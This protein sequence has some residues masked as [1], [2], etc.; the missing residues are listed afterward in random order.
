M[1]KPLF[2]FLIVLGLVP[3]L[4]AQV[5]V[6]TTNPTSEL[7][8]QT[9]NTGVPALELNPQTAPVGSADGQLSV[10]GDKLYMYDETRSKWLSI[11]SN[12]LQ[13]GYALSADNQVLWFGGDIESSTNGA[14][15]PFDGTIIH[16]TVSSSGGNAS[17][18]MDLQ[19]NGSNVGNNLD[20]TLDGRFNLS[21]GSFTYTDFNIDFS[22]GDF[23]SI[24]A[25]N[26]GAAVEDPAAIIWV[27]WRQ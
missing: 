14:I 6:G 11:E 8:I 5:G 27:K 12:P 18:R 4:V 13:Y 1:R 25:A 17:K 20:P 19:I 16:V 7:E 2:L 21:S 24:K 23:I 3:K 26:A 9:T 15:M 22:A 10:I